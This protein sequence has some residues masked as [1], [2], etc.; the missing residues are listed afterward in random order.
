VE[1]VGLEPEQRC[2]LVYVGDDG[3]VYEAG[4]GQDPRRLTFGWSDARTPD[5]L[6]YVWPAFSPDGAH[7]ACFGV[8]TGDAPEAG[9]Y[10]V[11]ENGVRMDEIWR[12][13]EAAPVCESWSADSKHIALLLQSRDNLSLE[14]ASLASPGKTQL[15]DRGAPLFWSWAPSGSMIAVHTGGSRSIYDEARLT[16]FDVSDGVREV[17]R[18]VP[19]EFR[20]PTWS[21]DGTRVAYVDGSGSEEMLALYWPHEGR[22]EL[23]EPVSGQTVMLWA[24]DGSALAVSEASGDSPH[25]YSGVR[26]VDPAGGQTRV[27]CEDEMISFFWS[28]GSERLICVAFDES[29][30]MRWSLVG[31]DGSKQVLP[32]TFF[33]S[34]ELVYFCWFFDQFAGSH[35]LISPDGKQLVFAGQIAGSSD[36]EAG[37]TSVYV[38]SLAGDQG[39]ERLAA[40]HFACWDSHLRQ[41]AA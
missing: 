12:M 19:G 16:I 24:P 35:P 29:S 27:V 34:R 25:V 23:I 41:V 9:L 3:D 11:H 28:P 8:R 6:Y 30:G 38:T 40:G 33:P 36:A 26:L 37:S 14:V 21:P 18:L 2:R 17:D 22:R 10:T 1:V 20:T 32:T 39:V 7:V 4:G 5:R 13:T 15:L 31:K